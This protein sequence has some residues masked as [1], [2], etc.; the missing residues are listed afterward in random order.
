M[1][2]KR[3]MLLNGLSAIAWGVAYLL[4]SYYLGEQLNIKWLLSWQGLLALVVVSMIALL[5]SYVLKSNKQPL[6]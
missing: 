3:F 5:V 4:P 2:Y 6:N 1:P